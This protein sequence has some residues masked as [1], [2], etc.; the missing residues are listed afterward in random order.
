MKFYEHMFVI[1]ALN[2]DM[3]F[4]I[5]LSVR[6]FALHI[7]HIIIKVRLV[8]AYQEVL[9]ILAHVVFC[10]VQ[11]GEKVFFWH[12]L[13]WQILVAADCHRLLDGHPLEVDVESVRWIS[14][15][16]M[17]SKLALSVGI[18]LAHVELLADGIHRIVFENFTE[19]LDR[20]P[21]HC[22]LYTSPSPRD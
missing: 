14:D 12:Y 20:Q 15:G 8:R 18:R 4:L 6:D 16:G 3:Y 22:L 10:L 17:Y 19:L 21:S 5:K 13:V 2:G 11:Q 1:H 7:T 9:P